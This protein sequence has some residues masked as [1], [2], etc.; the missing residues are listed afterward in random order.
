MAGWPPHHKMIKNTDDDQ[1][2]QRNDD[3]PAFSVIMNSLEMAAYAEK[4]WR[5]AITGESVLVYSHV[6]CIFTEWIA[7]R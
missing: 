5:K 4:V 3:S 1:H 7:C 2:T 6:V